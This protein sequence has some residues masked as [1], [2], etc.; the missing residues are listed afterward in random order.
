M[1]MTART[2][3]Q[4]E[5]IELADF[6]CLLVTRCENA[7]LE[8]DYG[9]D[10][11]E[12]ETLWKLNRALGRATR[13]LVMRKGPTAAAEHLCDRRDGCRCGLRFLARAEAFLEPEQIRRLLADHRALEL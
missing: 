6:A 8:F 10:H 1:K 9:T 2:P 12:Y 7:R 3:S 11:P 13:R 4:A 5:L